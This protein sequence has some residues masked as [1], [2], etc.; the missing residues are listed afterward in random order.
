MAHVSYKPNY[1]F[2]NKYKQKTKIVKEKKSIQSV[3][4]LSHVQLFEPHEPQHTR[5]PYLSPNPESTQTHVH[6]VGDAI[7]P[8][9]TSV[10]PFSS[11][12]PSF[13][14]SGPFQMSQLFASGGQS[15]GV[16]VSTSVLLKNT[17]D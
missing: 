5:T 9:H 7:Q 15:I 11:C 16:S 10:I 12:P 2:W 6:R 13:P 1:V 14:A 4:S 3:Y 8:S 17:Q